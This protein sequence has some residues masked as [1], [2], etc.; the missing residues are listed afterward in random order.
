MEETHYFIGT[1]FVYNEQVAQ[2]NSVLVP[3]RTETT[4]KIPIC[5]TKY[6][7]TLKKL[8]HWNL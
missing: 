5:L 2:G 3:K 8:H 4:I 1:I 6:F 7:W